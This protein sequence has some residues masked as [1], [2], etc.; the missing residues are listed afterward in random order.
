VFVCGPSD[1]SHSLRRQ[2]GRWVVK[3]R[4]IY[5]HAEEFGM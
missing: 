5:W 2:V 4:D 1:L 3:G